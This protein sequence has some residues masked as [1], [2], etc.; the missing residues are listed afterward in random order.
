MSPGNNGTEWARP[1][2]RACSL[3]F[4]IPLLLT[5]QLGLGEDK[6]TVGKVHDTIL[7]REIFSM[8]FDELGEGAKRRFVVVPRPAM[9]QHTLLTGQSERML[10]TC[11]G[12][13]KL[14]LVSALC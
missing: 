5:A 7:S 3:L 10:S 9:H 4:R 12:E 6:F 13:N 2:G 1:Y 8:A 11:C 14:Q